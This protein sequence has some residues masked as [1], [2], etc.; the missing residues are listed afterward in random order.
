MQIMPHLSGTRLWCVRLACLG[1]GA[2]SIA[3]HAVM[4]F[5]AA[6]LVPSALCWGRVMCEDTQ[7]KTAPQLWLLLPFCRCGR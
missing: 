4:V 5:A 7:H 3:C 1:Y 6:Q 2:F